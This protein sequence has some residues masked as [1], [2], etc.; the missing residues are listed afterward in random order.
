MVCYAVLQCGMYL[1]GSHV[2]NTLRV[3]PGV[4]TRLVTSL[5]RDTAL[6]PF[7]PFATQKLTIYLIPLELKWG[8]QVVER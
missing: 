7:L 8:T 3:I 2:S 5:P 1:W 6:V 4:S